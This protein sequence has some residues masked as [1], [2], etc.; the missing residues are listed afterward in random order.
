M[1]KQVLSK[2]EDY[3]RLKKLEKNAQERGERLR[4]KDRIY[5]QK[6]KAANI[7]VSEKEIDDYLISSKKKR[8]K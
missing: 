6:A 1:S 4:A 8:G 3:E 5:I 7:S 2:D